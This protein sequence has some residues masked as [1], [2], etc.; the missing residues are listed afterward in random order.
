MLMNGETLGIGAYFGL[1]PLAMGLL[2]FPIGA[3][4]RRPAAIV[5]TDDAVRSDGTTWPLG[6]IAD[7]NIRRGSRIN[8][9]EPPPVVHRTPAGGLIYGSKSTSA[10]FSRLL[11]R[12]MVERAYLISLRTRAGSDETVLAGGLTL[13]CAEALQR[14]LREEL[15]KRVTLANGGGA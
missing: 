4:Y 7:F 8:A 5:F 1:I 6:E 13:D 2:A 12:R 11:N 10:M 15:S 9:Q 3:R 14:D